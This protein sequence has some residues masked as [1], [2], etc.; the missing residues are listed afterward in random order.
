[1]S[2]LVLHGLSKR[3]G[4]LVVFKDVDMAV[5]RGERRAIIGPNG[6]GKTTLFGLISGLIKPSVGRV[7]MFGEDVTDLPS[8][9]RARRGLGRTFQITDLFGELSAIDNLVLGLEARDGIAL[10][11]LRPVRSYDALYQRAY[12]MLAMWGLD[13]RADTAVRELGYGEQ[14]QVEMLLALTTEP[15]LLLLDEPT[16]GLSPAETQAVADLVSDLPRDITVVLIEH[17]MDVAFQLA[18]RVTVLHAGSVLA[19]GTPAEV[20]QNDDVLRVY[21]GTDFHL[22]EG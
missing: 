12:E 16:A 10:S 21:L 18:E 6:A 13:D 17:D 15:R 4:A 9:E 2:E 8:H 20:R 19:E 7:A 11:M 14:R 3:F 1:M 5:E 22:E